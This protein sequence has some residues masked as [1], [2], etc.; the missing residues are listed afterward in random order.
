MEMNVITT[1]HDRKEPAVIVK[2]ACKK[3]SAGN[4]VLNG[5]DMTVPEGTM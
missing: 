3:Y 4:V 1:N 2:N 5:L